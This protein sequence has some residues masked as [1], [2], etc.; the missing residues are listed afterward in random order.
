[1]QTEAEVLTDHNELICST[2]IERIVTGRET[3]LKENEALILQLDEFSRLTSMIGGN[4]ADYRAMQQGH[5][6]DCWLKRP[7]DKA[8]PVELRNVDSDGCQSP[9]S[10]G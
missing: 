1:M 6:F 3:A 8:M 2:I 7:V 9:H 4:T 10:V 5:Y